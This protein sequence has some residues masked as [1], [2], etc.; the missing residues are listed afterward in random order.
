MQ[1]N[2]SPGGAFKQ[3]SGLRQQM[4]GPCPD[5]RRGRDKHENKKYNTLKDGRTCLL[6]NGVASDGQVV[7][8]VFNWTHDETDYL[9]TYSDEN[10]FTASQEA[11]FLQRK[12]DS[13]NTVEIIAIVDGVVA[14]TAGIDALGMRDKIKHRAV[15]GIAITKEFWGLGIGKYLMEACIECAREAGYL[16]LELEVV[17][18][19]ERAVEMYRRAGFIEYGRN[20]KAF[21]LRTGEYQE[22]IDMRLELK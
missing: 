13:T 21:R 14:G 1:G 15:F 4:E 7:L 11:D 10:C 12:T 8:D 18:E 17:A 20:P 3:A 2:E 6:R 16:Q 19:N 22:L 5:K 9:L